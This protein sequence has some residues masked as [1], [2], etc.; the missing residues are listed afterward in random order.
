M[1][2]FRFKRFEVRNE[3]SAM[4]VNTDGVLLGASVSLNASDRRILDIGTGTGTIALMIAQRLADMNAE[5]IIKGIDIDEPS[6]QEARDNF[7]SSPWAASLSAE[8]HP[9]VD[10]EDAGWGLIVSNPPFFDNSL[11]APDERRN[12]ARH[13]DSLSYREI[14]EFAS[15]SLADEGRLALILPCDQEKELLRYGRSFSLFPFRLVRVRTTARKAP[16]RLIAE[17]VK[18]RCDMREEELVLQE[19]NERSTAYKELTK[20]FYL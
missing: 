9:L 14:M 5:Y 6:T 3:R 17:F 10:E 4:K 11:K 1:E 16:M 20:E 19:G 12:A 18:G 13:D 8:H 2:V 7:A 15:R